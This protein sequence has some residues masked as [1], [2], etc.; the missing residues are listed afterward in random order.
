MSITTYLALP[1]YLSLYLPIYLSI[2]ISCH[3]DDSCSANLSKNAKVTDM[4]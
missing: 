1:S 4:S 3:N 2:F